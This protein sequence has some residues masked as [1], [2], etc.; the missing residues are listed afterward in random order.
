M[1]GSW[2]WGR[3]VGEGFDRPQVYTG[4]EGSPGRAVEAEVGTLAYSLGNEVWEP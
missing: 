3:G 2:S 4:E 1:E